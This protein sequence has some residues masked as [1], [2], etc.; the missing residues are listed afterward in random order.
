MDRET[1]SL[2]NHDLIEDSSVTTKTIPVVEEHLKIDKQL[3]ETGFVR[4]S[5]KVHE[6]EVP[7]QIPFFTEEVE[8]EHVAINKYIESEFPQI[9]YEGDKV[10]I[11]VLK[12]EVIIQK[13]TLLVEE[14]HVSKKQVQKYTTENIILKK[15]E[16][17]VERIAKKPEYNESNESLN[18]L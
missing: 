12:E 9:R 18:Q 3:V 4:I 8:V 6:E 17:E 1:T 5:K 16:V 7:V 2:N 10:I 13:R 11:P 14:L 15:E